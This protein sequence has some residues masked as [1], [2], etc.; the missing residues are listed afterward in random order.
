MT[1]LSPRPFVS[2]SETPKEKLKRLI[3]EQGNEEL[4]EAFTNY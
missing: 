4:L 3:E 2:P 1:M